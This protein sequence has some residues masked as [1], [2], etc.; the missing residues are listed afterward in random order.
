MYCFHSSTCAI[1]M[2]LVMS[3]VDQYKPTGTH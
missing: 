1:D 2:I 3:K